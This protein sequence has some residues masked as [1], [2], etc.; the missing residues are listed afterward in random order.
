M[1][2]NPI[3]NQMSKRQEMRV[4]LLPLNHPG[5]A[6]AAAVVATTTAEVE[7]IRAEVAGKMDRATVLTAASGAVGLAPTAATRPIVEALKATEAKT[8]GTA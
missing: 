5:A 4:L 6:I 3:E 8:G 2:R 7:I 1:P